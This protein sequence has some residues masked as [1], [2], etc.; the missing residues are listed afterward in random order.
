MVN[1]DILTSLR[2]AVDHG[3]PLENAIKLAL[4][5]GYNQKDVQEAAQ[6][7]SG[8]TITSF[9]PKSS[10]VLSMPSQKTLISKEPVYMTPNKLP[11]IQSPPDIQSPQQKFQ[12]IEQRNNNFLQDISTIKENVSTGYNNDTNTY[13]SSYSSNA[14]NNSS[15]SE[16]INKMKPHESHAKE[17]LLLVTLLLLIG[18]LISTFIF[19]DQLLKLFSSLS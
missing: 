2:N 1:E 10:E 3:E 14:S 8:G 17:I 15:I 16:E 4:N 6:F 11:P 7:I 18:V 12:P 13:V 9:Q 5:S 19:K